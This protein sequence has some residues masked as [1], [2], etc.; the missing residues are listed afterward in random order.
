MGHSPGVLQLEPDMPYPLHPAV[1]HFPVA[2]SVL[3]PFVAAAGL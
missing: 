1:V 2:L 3:I